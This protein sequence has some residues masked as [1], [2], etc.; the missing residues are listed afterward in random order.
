MRSKLKYLI[1][2]L[3]AGSIGML[4]MP[5]VK[6]SIV[7]LSVMDIIKIGIGNYSTSGVSGEIYPYVQEY[8]QSNVIYLIVLLVLILAGAFITAIIN[9]RKAYIVALVSSVANNLVA[10]FICIYIKE[11][12]DEVKNAV[13]LLDL[14]KFLKISYPT[15]ILWILLYAVILTLCILG[16]ALW[17]RKELQ[18]EDQQIMPEDLSAR[19]NPWESSEIQEEQDYLS[20]KQ[21]LTDE[22]KIKTSGKIYENIEAVSSGHSSDRTFEGAVTGESGIFAGKV[23]PLKEREEVFFCLDEGIA[24]LKK[25]RKPQSV[26]GLYYVSEYQEYCVDV[27]MKSKIFLDSGQPLGKGRQYYLPRGADIYINNRENLFTLA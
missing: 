3:L 15:I 4:F 23:Y 14:G 21:I 12:M 20:R 16:I 24:F 25:N 22:N 1:A 8:L 18:Y 2:L 5:L 9:G 11:K 13:A 10:A 7:E 26:A 27:F 17:G 6:I 19:Q